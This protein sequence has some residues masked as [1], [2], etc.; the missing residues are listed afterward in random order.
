MEPEGETRV[1]IVPNSVKK[2]L[3]A[4]FEILVEKGAGESANYL[5]S[6]YEGAG[7]TISTRADVLACENIVCIRSF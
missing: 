1:G 7:A 2:L 6:E 4:G 3:K 5:D